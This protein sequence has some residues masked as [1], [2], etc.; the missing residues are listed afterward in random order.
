MALYEVL[1]MGHPKLRQVS[2]P[3]DHEKIQT[4]EFQEFLDDMLA[5]MHAYGGI[6]LA[7]PQIGVLERIAIVALPEESDRYENMESF[8]MNFYINPEW[9]ILEEEKIGMWEGCLSVPGLRGYVER[10]S[11]LHVSY[12]DRNG[13]AQ[14]I[15]VEGLPAIVFQHEF[16]H[17]DG[18]LY[19]DRI[20]DKSK[21]AFDSEYEQFH[22]E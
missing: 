16:D 20:T 9:K 5:T 8:P 3:V 1:R 11:K 15:E 2:Q 7:A 10:A 12:F 22:M 6:G 14:E 4:P 18:K 17:L 21:L 19:V 13:E